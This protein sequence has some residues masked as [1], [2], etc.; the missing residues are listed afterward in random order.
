MDGIAFITAIVAAFL[1]SIVFWAGRAMHNHALHHSHESRWSYPFIWACAGFCGA[2]F[3][4]REAEFAGMLLSII[5]GLFL[6]F[7]GFYYLTAAL[8]RATQARRQW[9]ERSQ[10]R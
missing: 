9:R 2:L 7:G 8:A 6:G 10:G 5:T 1:G 4:A 3:L